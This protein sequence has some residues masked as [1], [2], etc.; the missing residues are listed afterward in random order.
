MVSD[1]QVEEILR[2]ESD[3][4]LAVEKLVAKANESGG[5]DNITVILVQVTEP[6][7]AR[8]A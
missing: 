6:F 3:V 4:K 2:D 7:G 8:A 5:R 1:E